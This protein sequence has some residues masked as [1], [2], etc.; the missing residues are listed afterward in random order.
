[1]LAIILTDEATARLKFPPI[2]EAL[3]KLKPS[4]PVLFAG[5]DEGAQ[6]SLAYVREL[7]PLS[8]VLPS[9]ER[10]FRALA[11]LTAFAE[12]QAR[13]DVPALRNAP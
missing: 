5:L 3:R 6:I 13:P 11:R 8:A 9:P 4:K 1:M 7:A 10:A 2:I 12:Q